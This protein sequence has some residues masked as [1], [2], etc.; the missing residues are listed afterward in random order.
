VA[1]DWPFDRA[2]IV[3]EH[4]ALAYLA[5]LLPPGSVPAVRFTDD[6]AFAFGM[7]AAP[8]GGVL[9]K[10]ALLRGD[11]DLATARRA[12]TLLGLVHR[13]SA[14]DPWARQ[15]F[16]D[17]GVLV[18]GR[19]D[20]YH[21]TTAARHPEVAALIEAE[22]ER[23]LATR[24]ALVLGDYAPKNAFAY[25][26]RLLI[27]DLEVAHWGDPAFDVAFCLN[28][29][30]L[31][32]VHRPVDAVRY[33]AA[34]RAFVEA[35][36]PDA[37]TEAATVREL[38]CLLLARVDGKSPAEYLTGEEERARVRALAVDVLRSDETRIE[39]VLAAV[40]A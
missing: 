38:G 14:A 30:C 10:T 4:R 33:A 15:A 12:G 11:I 29:L 37:A 3:N 31:K 32:A 35:Y 27:L 24:R 40:A 8:P 1:D 18:Q 13:G 6:D 19:V 21:R 34:A 20:P 39:P 2:R 25:P 23:L 22:V 5:G 28:H 7:D 16:A 17:Q 9:W 36:A 26:D